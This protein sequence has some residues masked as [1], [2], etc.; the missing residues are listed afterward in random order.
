[1][2]KGNNIKLS[3]FK[4][5]LKNLYPVFMIFSAFMIIIIISLIIYSKTQHFQNLA[6]SIINRSLQSIL[7]PGTKFNF[8]SVSLSYL[9][10]LKIDEFQLINNNRVVFYSKEI[11]AGIKIL[12]LLRN[13]IVVNEFLIDKPKIYLFK[14]SIDSIWN[15]E[16]LFLPSSDTTP[17]EP[18]EIKIDINR[19]RLI[20]GRISVYDSTMLMNKNEKFD[21]YH[22]TLKDFNLNLSSKID[23]KNNR[24]NFNVCLLYT[25]PSPRDS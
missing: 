2:D 19:V 8:K 1:M 25:S 3:I 16:R 6:N 22:F 24:Y 10:G 14:S 17:S 9:F 15:V 21:Y 5:L 13:K 12:P 23:L 18:S 11:H 20:D 7:Q 4:R